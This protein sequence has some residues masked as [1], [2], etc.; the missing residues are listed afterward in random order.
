MDQYEYHDYREEYRRTA[1]A[2]SGSNGMATA[3]MILG[4]C[5]LL[6]TCCCCFP[7]S[8]ICGLL[9]V[10]FSLVSKKGAPMVGKAR[11]GLAFGIIGLLLFLLLCSAAFIFYSMIGFDS[12]ED[13]EQWLADYESY[14]SSPEDYP[15]DYLEDLLDRLLR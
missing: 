15:E 3:S 14:I 7:I 13:A 12:S 6:V 11:W 2:T 5:S 10:I 8:F 1:P 9:A 4:I